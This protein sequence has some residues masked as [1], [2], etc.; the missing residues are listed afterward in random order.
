MLEGEFERAIVHRHQ[1]T[2]AEIAK[3][4]HRFVRPHVNAAKGIGKVGADGQQGDFGLEARADF[5]E[6]VKIGAVP[7]VINAPPFVLQNETAVATMIV[8][9]HARA[10][11]L[12][13]RQRHFPIAARKTLPPFQFDDPLEAQAVGKVAHTPRHHRNLG[14]RQAA[15]RW[16]VKVIEMRVSQQNQV[17]RREMIDL[18]PGALQPLQ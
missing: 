3:Y 6:A 17:D 4:L 10:P 5:F 11:V 8:P 7:G 15:E 14:M 18:Q 13:R 1:P 16:F 9:Q 2:G 12:A